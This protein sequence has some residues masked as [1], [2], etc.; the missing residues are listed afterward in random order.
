VTARQLVLD[1]LERETGWAH[2]YVDG[3]PAPVVTSEYQNHVLEQVLA[4]LG[5]PALTEVPE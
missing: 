3:F 4:E 2:E 5:I 1:L